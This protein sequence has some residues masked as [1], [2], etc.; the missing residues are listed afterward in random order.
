MG[1][2]CS[3]GQGLVLWKTYMR[4]GLQGRADPT[5]LSIWAWICLA[6]VQLLRKVGLVPTGLR[7]G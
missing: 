4:Q 7:I 3:Q 2:A 1:G 5:Q 6:R